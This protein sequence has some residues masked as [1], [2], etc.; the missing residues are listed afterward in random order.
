VFVDG[1]G[2]IRR[3]T[4]SAIDLL[5][6]SSGDEGRPL[7]ALRDALPDADLGGLVNR[8]ITRVTVAAAET[9]STRG[10]WYALTATPYMTASLTI[11]GALLAFEDIDARKRDDALAIDVEEYAEKLLSAI[12]H[13]LT[14]IDKDLRVLW[15]NASF[16]DYFGCRARTRSTI[17]SP[18]SATASG[19]TRSSA[20]RSSTRSTTG[21]RSG[22]SGS[23]MNSR[24][25]VRVH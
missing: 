16:L 21:P 14:V 23:I 3:F 19:R 9:R 25:S 13:P 18:T 2:R 1:G 8:A 4:N 20:T 6:L 17:C 22:A 24:R 15:V 12:P 7:T 5:G 10:H 11:A